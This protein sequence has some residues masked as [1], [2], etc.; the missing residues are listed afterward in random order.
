MLLK[1]AGIE[2]FLKLLELLQVENSSMSRLSERRKI[3]HAK[4][5]YRKGLCHKYL[6]QFGQGIRHFTS[7][8]MLHD[9]STEKDDIKECFYQR[10]S[11]KGELGN[12]RGA[13]EDYSFV[14]QHIGRF[15]TAY[16]GMKRMETLLNVPGSASSIPPPPDIGI[17]EEYGKIDEMMKDLIRQLPPIDQSL[18]RGA[19]MEKCDNCKRGGIKLAG[20]SLCK[21]RKYCSKDCQASKWKAYHKYTCPGGKFCFNKGLPVKID[22]LEKASQYN[23][24]KG[25]ITH[26][27]ED[28][29]RIAVKLDASGV[30]PAK[31]LSLSAIYY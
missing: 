22:G 2:C 23:G 8:M 25:T 21:E 18:S 14:Y 1:I 30:D 4:V 5:L 19:T 31:E 16:K 24:R 6:K 17:S 3:F 29:E 7:A 26:L 11:C 9:P 27:L 20:C 12:Y 28:K 10:A 13:L 15:D